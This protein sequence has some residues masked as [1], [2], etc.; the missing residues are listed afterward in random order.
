[1]E[2]LAI[3]LS[4]A[5]FIPPVLESTKFKYKHILWWTP[6]EEEDFTIRVISKK[7]MNRDGKAISY[8]TGYDLK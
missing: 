6:L 7:R 8:Q 5:L 2:I 1:M 3:L 4:A